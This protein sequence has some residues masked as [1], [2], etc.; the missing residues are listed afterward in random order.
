MGFHDAFISLAHQEVHLWQADLSLTKEQELDF[1][2]VLSPEEV[3]RAMRLRAPQHKQ[4]FIAAR[5][6]LRFL[7]GQYLQLAPEAIV[8]DY[9]PKGKPY[10]VGTD[11]EFNLSHSHDKAVF[12]F[13]RRHAIGVDI[14]KIEPQYDAAVVKRFFSVEEQAALAQ[15]SPTQAVTAFYAVWSRK[16]ALIKALGEGLAFSLL[17][18]SVPVTQP[19]LERHLPFNGTQDWHLQS[20]DVDSGFQ[21]AFATKQLVKHVVLHPA[22]RPSYLANKWNQDKI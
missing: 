7:L 22:L 15:M 18:I 20:F 11:L 16:E 1:F 21:A 2:K 6:Y 5:G 10:L 13:T 19:V 8:L 9:Y 14:E 12:A 3:Q 17:N 4:Y